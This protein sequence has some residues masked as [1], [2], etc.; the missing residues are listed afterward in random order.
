MKLFPSHFSLNAFLVL[1]FVCGRSAERDRVN[2]GVMNN[3]RA[4]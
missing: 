1:L 3:G 2:S 4:S